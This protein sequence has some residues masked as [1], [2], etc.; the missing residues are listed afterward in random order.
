MI[1]AEYERLTGQEAFEELKDHGMFYPW[2]QEGR[3]NN[4]CFGFH[5]F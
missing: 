3:V 1:I 5:F 2:F 4:L